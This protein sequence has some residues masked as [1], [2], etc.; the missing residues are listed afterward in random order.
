MHH[1]LLL[2]LAPRRLFHL[3]LYV[4]VI[5]VEHELLLLRRLMV[6]RVLRPLDSNGWSLMLPRC[7]HLVAVTN[8]HAVP[9]LQILMQI[10]LQLLRVD[11]IVGLDEETARGVH[12]RGGLRQIVHVDFGLQ[13][14][15]DLH[16]VLLAIFCALS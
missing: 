10:A 11:L 7:R 4:V 6:E 3:L 9:L 5:E 12:R 2:R 14:L 15:V 1:G 16:L 8:R 13:V